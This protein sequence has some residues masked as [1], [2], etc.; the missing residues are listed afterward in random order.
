[1]IA[2]SKHGP[3]QLTYR[4]AEY[5]FTLI[6]AALGKQE[7]DGLPSPALQAACDDLPGASIPGAFKDA[8]TSLAGR[9]PP[10][11]RPDALAG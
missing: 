5:T 8:S 2:D 7:P 10:H 4:Q 6:T 11:R 1:V 3:H 9:P